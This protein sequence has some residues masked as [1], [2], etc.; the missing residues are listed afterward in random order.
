M[1]ARRRR[2]VVLWLGHLVLLAISVLLLFPH[3]VMLVTSLK[4]LAEVYRSPP[5]WLPEVWH[6]RNYV[7]VWRDIPFLRYVSNSIFIAGGATLLTT[8]AAIPA[9]FAIARQRFRGR[10]F[11]L[12]G[13]MGLQMFGPEIIIV[14]LFSAMLLY[15]LIDK[16]GALVLVNSA[17]NLPFSIWLLQGYIRTIPGELDDAARID[18]ASQFRILTAIIVPLAR[19]AILVAVCV[20]FINSWNEFFGALALLSDPLKRPITVGLF[21]FVGL[22]E[23]KWHL[24]LTGALLS[25]VPM[26]LLFFVLLM[27]LGKNLVSGSVK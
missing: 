13:A 22:W 10:A 14:G 3:A 20:T 5:R 23:T 24:L 17:F 27:N 4:P 12:Y 2:L 19:P 11:F 21:S 9:A 18:G 15:G 16:L 6:W 25:T 26:I 1:R 7:D 8:L